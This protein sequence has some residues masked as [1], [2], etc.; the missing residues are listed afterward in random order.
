MKGQPS[1]SYLVIA[2]AIVIAGILIS[3]SLFVTAGKAQKT[4]T[5][6]STY[7]SPRV[8]QLKV[9]LNTTTMRSGGAITAEISISNPLDENVSIAPNYQANSSILAW[10]G[11][12]FTCGGLPASNP[13]WSLAGYALFDGHYTSANLSS[14]GDP[15]TLDT[16]L[17]A[18]CPA[19]PNPS[20]VVFLPNGSN[21]VAIFSQPNQQPVKRQAVM[22]ATTQVCVYEGYYNCSG[23]TSL[24]GYWTMPPGP[25]HS[26]QNATISSPYFHYFAPGEYTLVVEDMWGQAIY[27]YFEVT[28]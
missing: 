27:S 25:V 15:L 3:A 17:G 2:S 24:F 8:L 6:T 20:A 10:N 13:T 9:K 23:G 21:A 12:D 22:N 14:A 16:P 1:R 26:G 11:H 28:P 18:S 7:V 4:T 5:V 19:M